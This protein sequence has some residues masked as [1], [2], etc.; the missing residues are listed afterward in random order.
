MSLLLLLKAVVSKKYKQTDQFGVERGAV[1]D[2]GMMRI[3]VFEMRSNVTGEERD[4]T[5][6]EQHYS[7]PNPPRPQLLPIHAYHHCSQSHPH[8]IIPQYSSPKS[9]EIPFSTIP[10]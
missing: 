7:A 10:I 8:F 4:Q 5:Q 3:P 1:D 2:E 9:Q 6:H